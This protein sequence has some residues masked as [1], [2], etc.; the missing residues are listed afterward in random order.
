MK[1]IFLVLATMVSAFAAQA[2]LNP[3]FLPN[4][5]VVVCGP[6]DVYFVCTAPENPDNIWWDFGD[7]TTATGKSPVHAYATTGSYD[8]KMIVEKGSVKDSITKTGFV[9]INPA[10]ESDFMVD[11]SQMTPHPFVRKFI[12]TGFSNADSISQYTWTV[13]DVPVDGDAMMVNT[14]AANGDYTISLTVMN[15]KGCSDQKMKTVTIADEPE[16]P[17]AVGEVSSSFSAS[18]IYD[19]SALRISRSRFLDEQAQVIIRDISGRQVMNIPMA[20]GVASGTVSMEGLPDGT[21]IINYSSKSYV[22]VKRF[23]RIMM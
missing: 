8:V 14:F 21:Y 2:Q 12:F 23:S 1:T 11:T 22:A 4:H 16:N 15:N 19:Q 6:T 13:N 5:D 17:L 7:G 9:Q 18:V 10:P 3:D 20:P